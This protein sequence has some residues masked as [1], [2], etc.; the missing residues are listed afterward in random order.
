MRANAA[1]VVADLETKSGKTLTAIGREALASVLSSVARFEPGKPVVVVADDGSETPA[2]EWFE[3]ETSASSGFIAP[4]VA[5]QTEPSTGSMT[6][7]A[8]AFNAAR[9]SNEAKAS[10]AR[11]A[12]ERHGNPWNSTRL[13]RSVQGLIAN[14]DPAL[15]ERLRAEAAL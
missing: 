4:P 2:T 13:N 1:A 7:R 11:E 12:F 8:L 10:A 5:K 3:R 15:A 14:G 9:K 6:E